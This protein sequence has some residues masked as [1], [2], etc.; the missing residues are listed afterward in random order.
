MESAPDPKKTWTLDKAALDAFLSFLDTN[1]WRAGETYEKLRQRLLTF[2][3]GRG[4]WNSEE[5]VDETMDRLIRKCGETEVRDLGSFSLAIARRVAA[6]G[7][8]NAKR[9]TPIDEVG[10]PVQPPSI[11]P[12]T[13]QEKERR[14]RCLDECME[15]LGPD[16]HELVERWYIYDKSEKAEDKRRLA[17]SRGV[18][19]ETLR[20]QAHRARQRLRKLV[21]GCLAESRTE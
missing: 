18:S 19:L 13:K 9:A 12:E 20:V 7:F 5:L 1:R 17:E 3:R 15:Q 4:C 14:L 10:E 8:K 11:D 21:E 2:F 6:E 16:D